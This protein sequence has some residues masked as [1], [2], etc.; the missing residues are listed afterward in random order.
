MPKIKRMCELIGGPADGRLVRIK[1]REVTVNL[2]PW[3]G[4]RQLVYTIKPGGEND[5]VK[6][7]DKGVPYYI[8]QYYFVG[9]SNEP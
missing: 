7:Y 4:H 2:Y 8:Y 1:W 9:Y 3:F 5:P 6:R